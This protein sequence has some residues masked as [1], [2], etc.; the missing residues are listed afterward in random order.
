MKVVFYVLKGSGILEIENEKHQL[1]EGDLI[2]VEA[3]L[4]RGWTNNTDEVL[5]LLVLKQMNN[6]L[7]D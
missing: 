2:E 7:T 5:D 4:D 3:D 1:A 6:R